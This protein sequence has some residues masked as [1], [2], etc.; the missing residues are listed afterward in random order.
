MA[1]HTDIFISS[2]SIDLPEYRKVVYEAIVELGMFPSGMERWPVE[3]DDPV[4]KCREMVGNAE[5]FI[6]IYA[7]RYGW[8]PDGE[9]GASI[10]E[11]EY[12]WAANIPRFC[13]I[14][15]ETHPYPSDEKHR[16]K[17]SHKVEKLEAFK[18]RVKARQVGFFSTADNLKAQ[19][20]AA[21]AQYRLLQ[22]YAPLKTYLRWL[23]NTSLES[24]LL[25]ALD[26]RR[27]DPTAMGKNI[28]VDQV[29]TPLDVTR[30][31]YRDDDGSI[32]PDE[33]QRA[34][35]G[36][37]RKD[38]DDPSPLAAME[39]VSMN[40]RLVLLGD[41]GGGKSTFV[42]FLA[43][44]L[45]GQVLDPGAGWLRQIATQGWTHDGRL[46]LLIVLRELAES[47]PSNAAQG[48]AQH[49]WAFLEAELEKRGGKAALPA[50][51]AALGKGAALLLFDGLDEV[52]AEKRVIIRDAVE[53]FV[54]T[55]HKDNRILVTCRILNYADARYKLAG[56]AE[57][58][59]APFDTPK[60]KHF[61]RA[62]YGALR[63]LGRIDEVTMQARVDDLLQAIDD[64]QVQPMA[65][66]PMLLTVMA[67]VH[68]HT[69]TLPRET[70]RLYERCVDLLLLRW[71]PDE[72]KHLADELGVK[73]GDLKRMLWELAYAAHEEQGGSEGAANIPQGSI[74]GI[75]S[76]YLGDDDEQVKA[77]QF[78]NYIERR[79][80]LLIGRGMDKNGQRIFSFPHRTFQEYLAGCYLAGDRFYRR[81]DEHAR[82]GGHW[83]VSLL[84]ATGHLLFNDDKTDIPLDAILNMCPA[85]MQ[86][87]SDEDWRVVALAGEMLA[88]V[89]I[90]NA[91]RDNNG[92]K[93]LANTRQFLARLLTEGRLPPVERAAA[94]RTL[95]VLGDGRRGVGTL[96]KPS[97][98]VLP[99]IVC[100]EVIAA[101]RYVIGDDED[102]DNPR[103]EIEIPQAYRMAK[104]PVTQ[105][106]YLAFQDDVSEYG[107]RYGEWWEGL[108]ADEDD[109]RPAVP[110]FRYDNHPMENVNWYQAVAFTQWL[111]FRLRGMAIMADGTVGSVSDL[112][113]DAWII[114]KNAVIRL[115][116]EHEWEV[117]ARGTDGR[118]YP[119]VG[120]FDAGKGNAVKTGIGMTS[121]V[122]IF[123]GGASPCGAL[124]MSGNVWEWC[125][126]RYYEP[127]VRDLRGTDARVL[128]GGSWVNGNPQSFRAAYRS[129][130][131]PQGRNLGR[132]F[133]FM[134]SSLS[135]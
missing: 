42:A 115:P 97:G 118:V 45:T 121:A 84:L 72:A 99:D 4:D 92:R 53:D 88:L 26:P 13:F 67:L 73:E 3:G 29:Y 8:Q 128:R 108:A 93:A 77:R 56:F 50:V 40:E 91:E 83:R 22:E 59:V 101:G 34:M 24:G 133:R 112:P 19:V 105:A 48:T 36:A 51:Q 70:A 25:R 116:H 54:K 43:L 107:Y 16:D 15:D 46:P 35:G 69:G 100:A 47:M 74:L 11:M 41:P 32:L 23:H 9:D 79:A 98:E 20:L 12:D 117:A 52:P 82:K 6:G 71:R 122:G 7:W 110:D 120:D 17:D 90:G 5:V 18:A 68:N 119:Y 14:M 131:A 80:G 64:P 87:E 61:V 123:P 2:T 102:E 96:K 38:V 104:Y 60:I 106:Q 31:V 63:Q 49:I 65:G 132:G 94:G 89:G 78:C 129:G 111:T 30:A 125:E 57:E 62:W 28:T 81:A 1:E 113:D 44:C 76:R 55:L 127:D 37:S 21:L 130:N 86:P 85:D 134:F 75:V 124:D 114:G 33:V 95:S 58:T 66:N 109:K 39:A 10:T 126:N 135:L 27:N 103:R